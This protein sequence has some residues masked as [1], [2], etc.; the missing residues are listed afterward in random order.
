[1]YGALSIIFVG[2]VI[3]LFWFDLSTVLLRLFG[4]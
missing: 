3:V 4:E 1:M 2:S